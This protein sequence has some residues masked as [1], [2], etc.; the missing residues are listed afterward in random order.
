MTPGQGEQAKGELARARTALRETT[1][2]LDAGL[3]DGAASRLYYAVF[4]AARAALTARGESVKTH[5]GQIT[6]F[7]DAFGSAPLLGRLLVLRAQADYMG[8]VAESVDSLPG[9]I[10]EAELFVVR[11][12]RL[13]GQEATRGIGSDPPADL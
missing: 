2:L 5:S 4:H 7:T 9:L 10:G 1:A 8:G 12:E 13:V 3:P 11:C 6:R